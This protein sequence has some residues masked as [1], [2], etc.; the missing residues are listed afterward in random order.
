MHDHRVS[1]GDFTVCSHTDGTW[2]CSSYMDLSAD[3]FQ[4]YFMAKVAGVH[5][6]TNDMLQA[7]SCPV[8]T[9][10]LFHSVQP[11]CIDDVV[12]SIQA[13][14]RSSA[15]VT[16]CQH[17]FSNNAPWSWRHSFAS[18]STHHCSLAM[19][20]CHSNPHSSAIL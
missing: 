11:Y 15:P 4:L 2:L 10:L 19:S 3:D 1:T 20:H 5:V 7:E 16:H 14:L 6:L 9:N 13:F 8:P 18:S 17:S 12:K